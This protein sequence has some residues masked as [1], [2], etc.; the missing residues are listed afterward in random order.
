VTVSIAEYGARQI[1]VVGDVKFRDSSISWRQSLCS[2][3]WRKPDG[4]LPTRGGSAAFAIGIGS[5]AEISIDELQKNSLD[6][7]INVVLTGGEV[8]NVPEAPKIWVTGSVAHPQA[9]P[10]RK[11][12]DATV[13]R[14]VASVQGL[15]QYYS[16][17]AYIYRADPSDGGRRHEIQVPLK[18]IMHRQAQ[19]VPL[20][21]DDILL[22]PDESGIFRRQL[23]QKL[24]Q[25]YY[26]PK[27]PTVPEWLSK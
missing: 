4:R 5:A 22:M 17:V 3:G 15:T 19:D 7:T 11:P 16:K 6:L 20:L 21:A 8:I 23:L 18:E 13:L 2:S 14:V 26:D 9:I 27:P 24:Q 1:S 25:Q 10:I 12:G